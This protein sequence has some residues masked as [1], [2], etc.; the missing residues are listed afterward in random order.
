MFSVLG[1]SPRSRTRRSITLATAGLVAASGLSLTTTSADAALIAVGPID[2]ATNFPSFYRDPTGLALQPCLDGP[3]LCVGTA[4]ELLD[5]GP[6]GEGFYYSATTSVGGF[7]IAF[8]LEMAYLDSVTAPIVFQRLQFASRGNLLQPEGTYIIRHPYGESTCVADETGNIKNNACRT[9]TGGTAA[10]DF[11]GAM[12]GTIGPFLV[13]DT[14]GAAVGGPPP[15]YIGDGDSTPHRVKGGPQGNSVSVTGP[16]V[17]ATTDLFNVYG[18]LAPGPMGSTSQMSIDFGAVSAPVSSHITYRSVGTE[19]IG[20]GSV[21]ASGH[22]A[23]TGNTCNGVSL[24]SGAQCDIDVTF[25]PTPGVFSSG[26][27]SIADST[28]TKVIPLSGKGRLGVATLSKSSVVMADTKVGKE[29]SDVVT[30]TNA[31]DLDLTVSKPRFAGK[32][33]YDFRRGLIE[34]GCDTVATLAPGASCNVRVV[35]APR[36]KRVRTALLTVATSV[37]TQ[38]ISLAGTGVGKDRVVPVVKQ[39]SP[40]AGA[41]RVERG[42]DV[43]AQFSEAVRGVDK[44]SMRLVKVK[45]GKAVSVKVK[46]LAGDRWM[47][48]PKSKLKKDTTY[49]VQLNGSRSGIRDKAG[50]PLKDATWKFHTK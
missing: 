49:Q 38:A 29:R 36:A 32:N 2:P 10:N 14:F 21:T 27:V 24:S 41:K 39:E 43:V 46:K 7:D 4:D 6:A 19:A 37:G 5:S 8:D 50:N 47:L 44:G 22:F 12:G 40:K 25:T 1:S 16:G 15:G 31:G 33:R 18:K 17:S 35:F 11:A 9:E 3:P 34:N 42:S 30:V 20:V 48:D 26:A 23:I 45:S 28:G 13:W